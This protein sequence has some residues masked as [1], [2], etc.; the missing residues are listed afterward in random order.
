MFWTQFQH[1]CRREG[2]SPNGV[3]KEIGLSSGTVTFWKNGKIPKSDTL[4]KLAD[5]FGVTVD[6]LLGSAPAVTLTTPELTPDELSLLS[7]YR[8]HPELQAAVRKLLDIPEPSAQ[9]DAAS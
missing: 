1:L 9:E 8:S 2:K 5:Y 6:E 3:A 7:A 4:K